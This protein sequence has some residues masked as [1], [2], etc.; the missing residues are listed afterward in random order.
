MISM[1][2][3]R[4]VGNWGTAGGLLALSL[5]FLG[6]HSGPDKRFAEIPGLSA[7]PQPGG[8]APA[9]APSGAVPA[10][11]SATTAPAEPIPAGTGAAVGED[12]QVIDVLHA[13]MAVKITF[14]DLPFQV[15]IVDDRIKAD[16]TIT[17]MQSQTFTAEGKTRSQFEKEIHDRYVPDFFK[18]MTV[19]V[20]PAVSSQFYSVGGEVKRPDR[21]VY[22]SR[23]RLLAAIQSA[24]DFTDF[25][26]RKKVR[27]T[28][29]SG[30]TFIVNC[31]KAR[32]DPKLDVEIYPGDSVNVPRR[33][34]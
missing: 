7:Q 19:T 14:A 11:P 2:V 13:G 1:K 6:C 32:T 27:V 28:R 18:T 29:A 3:C 9:T 21:F 24:G 16:G 20:Q 8:R 5:I 33:I 30:Q 23:L 4:L 22:L 17:L 15:P 34:F 31:V 10:G 12:T 26:N 25:A